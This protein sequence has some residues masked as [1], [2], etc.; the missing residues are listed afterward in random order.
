MITGLLITVLQEVQDYIQK[1]IVWLFKLAHEET[2]FI[3]HK[4]VKV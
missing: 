1:N 2:L 3:L 4:F